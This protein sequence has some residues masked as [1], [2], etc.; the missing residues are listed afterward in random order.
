MNRIMLPRMYTCSS[1]DTR[2]SLAVTVISLSDMFS[3]SSASINFPLYISPVFSSTVM[4]CPSDS[5][6][7]FM[8]TPRLAMLTKWDSVREVV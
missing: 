6:R 3:E 2:P 5:C 4:M 8:G 7:S 1:C